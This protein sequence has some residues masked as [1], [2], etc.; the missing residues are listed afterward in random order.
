[1]ITAET[2][3]IVTQNPPGA[4]VPAIEENLKVDGREKGQDTFGF[5]DIGKLHQKDFIGFLDI[6]DIKSLLV[7]IIFC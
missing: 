7:F 4:A 6:G 5:L 3:T 1:M 2:N